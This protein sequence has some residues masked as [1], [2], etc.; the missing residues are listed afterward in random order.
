MSFF[1]G[2]HFLFRNFWHGICV[3][4]NLQF[5]PSPLSA[6]FYSLHANQN[7]PLPALSLSPSWPCSLLPQELVPLVEP[8]AQLLLITEELAQV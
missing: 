4:Y 8:P 2:S 5:F 3:T 1:R 7:I 6:L